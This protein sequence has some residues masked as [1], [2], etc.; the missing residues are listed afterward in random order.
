M[1]QDEM[2]LDAPP[3]ARFQSNWQKVLAYD[4]GL[5]LPK[6]RGGARSADDV[7]LAVNELGDKVEGDDPGNA[8][9]LIVEFWVG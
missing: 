4:R 9:K 3:K 6:T 8:C 7:R 2:S 5:Y 1:L